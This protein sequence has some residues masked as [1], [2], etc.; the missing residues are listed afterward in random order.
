MASVSCS[1][2]C[3]RL[4]LALLGNEPAVLEV[5]AE[6]EAEPRPADHQLHPLDVLVEDVALVE[7]EVGLAAEH[8]ERAEGDAAAPAVLVD[9]DDVAVHV[10]LDAADLLIPHRHD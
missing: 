3:K 6:F 2:R 1:S 8:R 5:P 10:A 7:D 4:S 9:G